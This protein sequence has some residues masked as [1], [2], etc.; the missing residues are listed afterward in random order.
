MTLPLT[1][2]TETEYQAAF[3]DA[4]SRLAGGVT[5][6]TCSL[7]GR[8]WGMTVT[9][10]ASVSAEPPTVLVSLASTAPSTDAIAATGRFGVSILEQSRQLVA[11]Y[12]SAPGAPKF[13]EPFLGP[14]EAESES[15]MVAGALAHLDCEL[16][17]QLEV[18]DH[19]VFFG[20]V[21]DA[22]SAPSGRPLLYFQRDYRRLAEPHT[23]RHRRG[24]RP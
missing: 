21:R 15:P 5:I 9:A 11:R 19:T 20:R 13:L 8:P 17:E 22:R 12:C 1:K 6:V 10:V 24:A 4:M 23:S 7:D 14:H 2:P 3:A 18:A 16:V